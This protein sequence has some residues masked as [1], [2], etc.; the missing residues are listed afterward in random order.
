M[1][2]TTETQQRKKQSWHI[3]DPEIREEVRYCVTRRLTEK[4]SLEELSNSGYDISY[5]TFRRIKSKLEPNKQRLDEIIKQGYL[6]HAIKA[7]DK[8]DMSEKILLDL[9]KNAKTVSEKLNILR[10]YRKNSKDTLELY[11]SNPV[12][13]TLL[14]MREKEKNYDNAEKPT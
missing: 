4:E 11:D 13:S 5:R 3:R 12:I 6:V 8:L 14:Q 2:S 10:E 9:L 1:A 7:F